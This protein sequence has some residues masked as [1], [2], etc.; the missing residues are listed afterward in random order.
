M[1]SFLWPVDDDPH[2]GQRRGDPGGDGGRAGVQVGEDPLHPGGETVSQHRSPADI[3][4]SQ[5][6]LVCGKQDECPLISIV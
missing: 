2:A 6:S 1:A 3:T 5:K 4:R